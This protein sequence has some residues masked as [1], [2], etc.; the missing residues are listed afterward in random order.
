MNE[1]PTAQQLA[2][3]SLRFGSSAKP[4]KTIAFADLAARG[5][6]LIGRPA[7]ISHLSQGVI[8]SI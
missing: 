8:C 4:L 7:K 5:L 3:I 2:A 6:F 1:L